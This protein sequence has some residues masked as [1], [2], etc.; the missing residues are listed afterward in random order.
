M[1]TFLRIL[2]FAR[3]VEKYAIPYFFCVVLHALFNTMNFALLIP[4][5]TTLFD[6]ASMQTI[7][8]TLP[9][10]SL[11]TDYLQNAV[12]FLIYKQFGAVYSIHDVLVFISAIV[13]TSVLLSNAFR[14]AAQKIGVTLKVPPF[15]PL[16]HMSRTYS[17]KPLYSLR[18]YS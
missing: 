18:K 14:F 1:K 7:V 11:S 3:P 12:K 17:E 13:I 16:N 8:T 10:F 2:Q 9:E 15:S 6:G 5:L 4:I